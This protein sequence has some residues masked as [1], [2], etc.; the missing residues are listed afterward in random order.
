MRIRT[1]SIAA[2]GLSLSAAGAAHAATLSVGAG[3]TYTTPCAAIAAAQSG[4]VVEVS[5]GTYTD[6]CEIN[7]DNLTLRGVGSRPK[8]DLSGSTHPADYKGIYVVN[9]NNVTIENLELTGSH[10]PVNEGENGAA[11]R[12]QSQNLT[13]N[14]CYIHDNQD[15]MLITPSQPGA[16]VTVEYSELAKNGEGNGCDDGNSCTHN[17]YVGTTNVA[18]FVFQYNWTHQ[19]ANDTPDKGHLL[20]SRAQ[21][22]DVLYNR[23][24]GETGPDSYEIDLPNGGLGI[25][26]GNM[27][28]KDP[29]AGNSTLLDYGEEGLVNS[30]HRLFVASNTFVNDLG[31]G[32]FINVASGGTLTAHDNLF[33][34]GGT[35]SSS[36]ALSPDNLSG[37]NPLFVDQAGFDYHLTSGSPAID[38][39]VDPGNA[40]QFSLTPSYEYVQPTSRVAR[41]SDGKLDVGAFEYGTVTDAGPGTGGAAGSGGTGGGSTGT[42]GG[43]T[44]AGG[45]GTGTGGNGASAGATGT[46]GSRNGA[47]PSSSSSSGCGCRAASSSESNAGVAMLLAALGLA[48]TRRRRVTRRRSRH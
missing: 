5:P 41:K 19:I 34:G 30:D 10:I 42:G 33:V 20:K 7:V 1:T 8:I 23:I 36:G 27:V 47:K 26:V 4:D 12:D 44:S 6:S 13:V 9:G 48:Y 32:T 14:G 39:G 21:E 15:G 22:T 40:D 28:E 25:V 38:K 31:H 3:K 16:L 11:I 2:I 24:T 18:K 29:N 35:P 45:T 46:A 17:I 43:S 37:I